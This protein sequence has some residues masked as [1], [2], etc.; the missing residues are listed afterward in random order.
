MALDSGDLTQLE[1]AYLA[2]LALGLPPSRL[3]GDPSLRLD[4]LTAVTH[5][6]LRGEP[7]SAYLRGEGPAC[8][9]DFEE[10]LRQARGSL[11]EK[12]AIAL[13]VPP[14]GM[15]LIALQSRDAFP[16]SQTDPDLDAA[17][18][19]LDKFLSHRCLE[20]ILRHPE[21]HAFL[22]AKYA[23]ISVVWQRLRAEGYADRPG[24]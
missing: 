4:R 18:H 5:A 7:A 17:P 22:M 23:E 11:A 14:A 21:V 13:D 2:V 12:G 15:G 3:A 19:I 6:L 8:A 9:P 24:P 10:R 20:A 16:T 1:R